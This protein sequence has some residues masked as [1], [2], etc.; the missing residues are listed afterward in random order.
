LSNPFSSV[1]PTVLKSLVLWGAMLVL[2]SCQTALQIA[3][4]DHKLVA[5][6]WN[7]LAEYAQSNIVAYGVTVSAR[8]VIERQDDKEVFKLDSIKFSTDV[9][10]REFNLLTPSFEH[11]YIC[12]PQCF[13]LLEYVNFNGE[14]GATLLVDFFNQHEFELFQFY[15]DLVILSNSLRDL[16]A[17]DQPLLKAYLRSLALK[18]QQFDSTK[19]FISFLEEMLTEKALAEF[20]ENPDVPMSV[21]IKNYQVAPNEQWTNDVNLEVAEYMNQDEPAP[22]QQWLSAAELSPE[23]FEV[24]QGEFLPAPP[25]LA[26][27]QQW[28]NATDLSPEILEVTQG[29]SQPVPSLFAAEQQWLNAAELSPKMLDV[30]KDETEPDRTLLA[31]E[32]KWLSAVEMPSE[33]ALFTLALYSDASLLWEE[34]Q[35][36][37]IVVGQNFC[38]YQEN[39]F[40]VVKSLSDNTVEVSLLGQAKIINDGLIKN[41]PRGGLFNLNIELSFLPMTGNKVFNKTEIATCFLE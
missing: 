39:L 5:A 33:M 7:A 24:T 1:H 10:V 34:A 22:E 37:P 15:G 19:T 18:N 40:G 4:S 35:Q 2:I 27:E 28:L 11:K 30:N 17:K 41:L 13:Q 9:S 36:L 26:P 6:K 23:I 21:F 29:E 16:A 14:S 38:S 12:L 32:Q 25:L 20:L 8:L 3:G 31:P